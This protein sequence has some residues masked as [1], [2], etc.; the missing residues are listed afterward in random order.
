M[1]DYLNL[2][3]QIR[4]Q[5]SVHLDFNFPHLRIFLSELLRNTASDVSVNEGRILQPEVD[6]YAAVNEISFDKLQFSSFIVAKRRINSVWRQQ[7]RYCLIYWCET[8]IMSQC[9]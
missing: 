1:Y 2:R 3:I 9:V 6:K 5:L 8:E 7:S 4:G